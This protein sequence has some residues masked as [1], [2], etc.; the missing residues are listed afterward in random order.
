MWQWIMNSWR[1]RRGVAVAV[2]LIALVAI[3]TITFRGCSGS[4]VP[5][6]T[7]LPVS[8]VWTLLT[9]LALV[10]TVFTSNNTQAR[11]AWGVLSITFY[12]SLLS[13]GPDYPLN[14]RIGRILDQILTSQGLALLAMS[15]GV[16]FVMKNTTNTT[17]MKILTGVLGIMAVSFAIPLV[18]NSIGT[19]TDIFKTLTGLE[20]NLNAVLMFTV[21]GILWKGNVTNKFVRFLLWI[22]LAIF[23]P[24]SIAAGVTVIKKGLQAF[25]DELPAIQS[26]LNY[27]P[28]SAPGWLRDMWTETVPVLKGLPLWAKWIAV[29]MVLFVILISTGSLLSGKNPIWPVLIFIIISAILAGGLFTLQRVP[30]AT[31]ATHSTSGSS[32]AKIT[33]TF[34]N[35]NRGV[36]FFQATKLKKG[37]Y[38]IDPPAKVS[39]RGS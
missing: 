32:G 26:L 1:A 6:G 20:F 25:T 24:S 39:R 37:A 30:L 3:P 36:P 9:L 2:F 16:V 29:S 28:D 12:F 10:G 14:I 38:K 31:S 4:S 13:I 11:V 17:V 21:I 35:G 15:A 27:I 34:N 5:T 33:L 18:K 23:I 22:S 7:G 8:L 19:T